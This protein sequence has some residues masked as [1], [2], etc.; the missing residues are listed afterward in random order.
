MA[1]L[2]FSD[3]ADHFN[4]K[5]LN[6]KTFKNMKT[7]KSRSK[8]I[9]KIYSS[10]KSRRNKDRFVN[11]MVFTVVLFITVMLIAKIV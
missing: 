4:K 1:C 11:L 3:D 9:T 2:L 7:N 5:R 8:Q 10:S 6:I